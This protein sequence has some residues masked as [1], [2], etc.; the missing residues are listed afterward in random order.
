MTCYASENNDFSSSTPTTYAIFFP[1]FADDVLKTLLQTL[2][3]QVEK[4]ISG[5]IQD[6]RKTN[7]ATGPTILLRLVAVNQETTKILIN[8]IP[9]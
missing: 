8:K 3:N 5:M 6:V 4:T 9:R 7:S 2:F 1:R